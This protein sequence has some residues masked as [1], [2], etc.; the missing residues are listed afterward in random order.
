LAQVIGKP[1]LYGSPNTVR[2]YLKRV[3]RCVRVSASSGIP[4]TLVSTVLWAGKQLIAGQKPFAG[5]KA[6]PALL[7]VENTITLKGRYSGPRPVFTK[8]NVDQYKF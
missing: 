1:A 6:V 2:S 8:E 5:R 3:G 4:V 7:S